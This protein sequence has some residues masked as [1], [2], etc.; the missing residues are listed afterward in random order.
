MINAVGGLFSIFV[1]M[2]SLVSLQVHLSLMADQ[3]KRGIRRTLQ[4]KGMTRVSYWLGWWLGTVMLTLPASLTLLAFVY[5]SGLFQGIEV[6]T[7]LFFFVLFPLAHASYAN[8]V[9]AVLGPNASNGTTFLVW[10]FVNIVFYLVLPFYISSTQHKP[11]HPFY[12][13]THPLN[14]IHTSS[15]P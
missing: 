8:F 1:A 13:Y 10:R 6:G 9:V 15:I 11:L 4:M 3:I 14:H 2:S 12:D 5:V 7:C